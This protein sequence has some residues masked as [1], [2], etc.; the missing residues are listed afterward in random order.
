MKTRTLLVDSNYLLK[1]SISGNKDSYTINF[2]HIGG[3]YSFFTTIRHVIK[4]NKINKVVLMWDGENGGIYRYLIDKNYKANRKDKSW[5]EKVILSESEIK[6]EENKKISTLKQRKRVQAYAE[7]LFL[8]QVEIDEVEADDLIAS[9]CKENYHIEEILIY[10]N[11]RDFSQLLDYDVSILFPNINSIVNKNNF[12]TT[13]GYH[14]KNA[15]IMKI[16]C[17]DVSDNIPGVGGIKEG[18]LIDIFPDITVRPVT[19][20]EIYKECVKINEE[21]ILNKKKPIKKIDNIINGKE[22]MKINHQLV[23]LKNP[24]L[25]DLAIEALEQL[26]MPLS[27]VGRSSKNLYQMMI[28]D[29]FLTIYGGTFNNYVEPFYTVIVSEKENYN[30]YLKS[31]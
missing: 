2:G 31:Q 15:V 5:F 3:L 21:R 22:R 11:D 13:F 10:S 6:A 8:R 28:E 30:K 4:E 14:Y 9:Y 24:K 23:D 12:F 29:E 7:E 27:P 25:N 20:N 1:K 26:K 19:V 18:S 16:I 17:G